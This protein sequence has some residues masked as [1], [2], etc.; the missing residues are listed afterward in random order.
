MTLVLEH[1]TLRPLETRDIPDLL[2]YRNDPNIVDALGGFS[3]GYNETDLQDWLNYHR[4]RQDEVMWC[5]AS[6][7][8]DRCLGHAGLYQLD[9][10]VRKGE[11]ALMIGDTGSRGKGLGKQVCQAMMDYGF[12]QLNLRRIELSLLANNQAA[13]KLYQGLGF[14]Q[15][16]VLRQ[17]QYRAGAYV[18]VI[19]MA[20]IKD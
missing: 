20:I 15:E 13:L 12:S 19:L 5:I 14:E 2:A 11:L 1:V 4:N 17:A 8:D 6:N 7:D 9:H 16:G 10:R 3:T 18:D